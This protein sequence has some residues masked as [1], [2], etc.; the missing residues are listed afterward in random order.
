MSLL[1]VEGLYKSFGETKV[2]TDVNFSLERGI[3][4]S[5]IGPSGNGKTTLLRCLNFLEAPDKGK[6][7]INGQEIF[8][9]EKKYS[10]EELRKKRLHFGLVFQNFNLFPQ[11][12]ALENV[13]LAIDLRAKE[14]LMSKE[15]TKLAYKQVIAQ[16]ADLSRELLLKMGLK[17][18][19]NNYPHELSGGQQQRVAIARALSLTPD[20]ICFDEPTSALDP[21]LTNEVANMILEL[22]SPKC[23]MIIVTHELSFAQKVSDK[24][25]LM[26]NGIITE[27]SLAENLFDEYNI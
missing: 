25:L 5:I 3:I 2:L 24:I 11:Y 27:K 9:A 6:I 22:K 23:S 7:K 8:D 20:V 18:K 26:E 14:R 17:G 19:E 4:A 21:H 10:Q 1:Q 12:T 13:K 15:L 16:N